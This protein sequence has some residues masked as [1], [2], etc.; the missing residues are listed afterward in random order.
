MR[1][2]R[3]RP[4]T[5]CVR[6]TVLSLAVTVL[7]AAWAVPTRAAEQI[8]IRMYSG[9][10]K[11]ETIIDQYLRL[12]EKLNP[13]VKIENLGSEWDVNKLTTLFVAGNAPDIIQHSDEYIQ[14][15]YREGFLAPV[16]TDLASRM[17]QKFYPVLIAALTYNGRL[18]GVPTEN[19]VTGLWYNKQRLDEG[20]IANQPQ[21]LDELE[22][23]G[24]RLTKFAGD[25]RR[26]R[27]GLVEHGEWWSFNQFGWTMFKAL[28]GQ[29]FDQN[30]RLAL[31]GQPMRDLLTVAPRW[32]GPKGFMSQGWD[33]L[34]RFFQGEIPYGFGY[35][36]WSG[37]IK[38]N[39]KGDY[40]KDFGVTVFPKGP[41]GNGA[42][43][44]AHAYGVNARSKHQ[45][46]VWKL[47]DWLA[48]QPVDGVTP[49]GHALSTKSLP[50]NRDDFQSRYYDQYRPWAAGF[51][52]NLQGAWSEAQY[53]GY[54]I[55]SGDVD[56]ATAMWQVRDGTTN[57]A[58][59]IANLVQKVQ[60]KVNEFQKA[61]K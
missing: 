24:L 41:G 26:E 10:E 58:Q 39:Y 47:L 60:N 32:I 61:K 34:T 45:Q 49:L 2:I 50:V 52:A 13:N 35:L 40:L 37:I 53:M 11:S 3:W 20:G 38:D 12:Y 1:S 8:V 55:A 43:H 5:R 54:G 51:I 14:Q 6:W 57:P 36:W 42:F 18:A 33:Q 31:D 23:L 21:T 59:A 22:K 29:V 56:F 9:F 4:I 28:G 27:P 7:G 19:M 48:L 25:G 17:A 15:L 44:Y 30:G 46:E 16:P